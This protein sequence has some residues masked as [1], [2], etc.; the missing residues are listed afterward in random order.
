M[1]YY[2]SISQLFEQMRKFF[3]LLLS[4]FHINKDCI[5]KTS[6][7]DLSNGKHLNWKKSGVVLIALYFFPA[8]LYAGNDSFSHSLTYTP[9]ISAGEVTDNSKDLYT[10]YVTQPGYVTVNFTNDSGGLVKFAVTDVAADLGLEGT[11]TTYGPTAYFPGDIFYITVNAPGINNTDIPYELNV[12][13]TEAE[14]PVVSL[15]PMTKN[16]DP[17]TTSIDLLVNTTVCPFNQDINVTYTNEQNATFWGIV[18][19][20]QLSC[21]RSQPITLN[22]TPGLPVGT[23]YDVNLSCGNSEECF[24]GSSRTTITVLDTVSDLSI[25]KS[26]PEYVQIGS[27]FDFDITV[28]NNGDNDAFDVSVTDLVDAGFTL[29]SISA[30]G[31][32][33]TP[34]A[35]PNMVCTSDTNIAP[36]A[37]STI[38]LHVTAPSTSGQL[39]NAAYVS[40]GND[41]NTLNNSAL[42]NVKIVDFNE[43]NDICYYESTGSKI[44]NNGADCLEYDDGNTT[45]YYGNNCAASL[46]FGNLNELTILYDVNITKLY[47]P[48]PT[49]GTCEAPDNDCVDIHTNTSSISGYGTGYE[50]WNYIINPNRSVK[51][52]DYNTVL[53]S[54]STTPLE[55]AIYV[56]YVKDGFAYQGQM[57]SCGAGGFDFPE[58]NALGQMDVVDTVFNEN[59][60]NNVTGPVLKTK[61]VGRTTT[62]DIVYLGEDG[63]DQPELFNGVPFAAILEMA[64]KD[65]NG[66]YTITTPL[67][68]NSVPPRLVTAELIPAGPGVMS[69]TS[70]PFTFKKASRDA[71]IVARY[72]YV[73]ETLSGNLESCIVRSSTNGNLQ[74]VAS[75]LNSE[76]KLAEA[77]VATAEACLNIWVADNGQPYGP[78]SSNAGNSGFPLIPPYN[79]EPACLS[80]LIGPAIAAESKDNFAIRPDHYET[81]AD[82]PSYPD[83]LRAGKEYNLTILA[84][85][86]NDLNTTGYDQS[87]SAIS[88]GV[89]QYDATGNTATMAGTTTG[90]LTGG[91]SFTDGYTASPA[92]FTY[93]EVGDI[94]INIQDQNWSEVDFDDTDTDCDPDGAYV[95]GNIMVRFIPDHFS[96]SVDL[97][98]SSNGF[99]YLSD[100]ANMT[101]HMNVLIIAENAAGSPTVNFTNVPAERYENPVTVL[102][103]VPDHL[104]LTKIEHE[105]ATATLIGFTN[106]S[107]T[108]SWNES[109]ASLAFWFNYDRATNQPVNPF[110]ILGSEVRV[111]VNS[112]YSTSSTPAADE[113]TAN[114]DG[115]DTDDS[116][117]TF[118]YGRTHMPRTRAMCNG[119][120]CGGNVTFFYEF[121]GDKDANKTLIGNLLGTSPK[122]SVDSVNWYRNTLHNTATDGNV[123]SSS[124][125][126]PGDL[127]KLPAAFTH[128]TQTTSATYSYDGSKGYPY[129]GTV[130]VPNS[131]TL[132]TQSWLIYDKYQ[133]DPAPEISGELEYYGPGSWSSN[134]GAAE[135]VKDATGNKNRNTNRR[136]RW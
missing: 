107:R 5:V 64:E 40:S 66:E 123:T 34:A 124:Q 35:N 117:L 46:H 121:Y 133:P 114:I 127:I 68:D 27:A 48:S 37:S 32:N 120:P 108:L 132:G 28:V 126:I 58:N 10:V 4:F 73:S 104:P 98:N 25:T 102:M 101:P 118:V 21:V 59:D 38:T 88:S 42:V 36:G 67:Y 106:G 75:C 53:A 12:T 56:T 13:L 100:D 14:I 33:C 134:T 92:Q 44:A 7:S 24:V 31:W 30:S 15:E 129:K 20:D 83:L 65:G 115:T 78:C 9:Y 52:E 54:S 125:N 116:N 19:Y 17:T 90:N 131:G 105:L 6:V 112:T 119:S 39:A 8:A 97:N 47:K 87:I 3:L 94:A 2:N 99:T 69:A 93:D 79:T 111:D 43:A 109:N 85:D 95:C 128:S 71:K 22:V 63:G 84:Y 26:A 60:Y 96:V 55:I 62:V 113:G 50:L 11:S 81:S 110:R 74:D 41:S 57:K 23:V 77:Y 29:N 70:V 18:T 91:G 45:F 51:I 136:I 103:T 72:D 16:V 76:D 61:V 1:S 80:C 135:S 86:E 122:R 89:I 49:A 82:H 130:R